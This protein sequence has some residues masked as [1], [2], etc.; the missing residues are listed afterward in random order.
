MSRAAFSLFVFGSYVAVSGI[1]ILAVPRLL[2]S[3][4]HLPAAADGWVRLVGLLALV[5]GAYDT[6]GG[7]A[8]LLP[9]IRAS[10]W[11][12]FGFAGGTIALVTAGQMPPVL[13]AF[14]AADAAG[15]VWT[16]LALRG[17][18]DSTVLG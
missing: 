9:Y 14:G 5:I 17:G 3:A 13:L 2:M 4:L 12:R 15:A 1:V 6:V 18:R 16:M 11:V 10:V 8:G 7:R